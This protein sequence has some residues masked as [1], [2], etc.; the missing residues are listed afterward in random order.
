MSAS[1]KSASHKS[2]PVLRASRE[3]KGKTPVQ[4]QCTTPHVQD[5]EMHDANRRLREERKEEARRTSKNRAAERTR[6]RD[7]K[8]GNGGYFSKTRNTME[9]PRAAWWLL[10]EA[11]DEQFSLG[12]KLVCR[13]CGR[14]SECARCSARNVTVG[15]IH[16]WL[17]RN[18]EDVYEQEH[19]FD[20]TGCKAY[21]L[22]DRSADHTTLRDQK[23]LQDEYKLA[24]YLGELWDQ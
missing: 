4:K 8:A 21:D 14:F 10:C 15:Q 12:S 19:H 17:Q 23:A 20:P 13:R 22:W 6:E 7:D 1:H 18:P 11:T 16:D 5:Q 2:A 9:P 3:G 24:K